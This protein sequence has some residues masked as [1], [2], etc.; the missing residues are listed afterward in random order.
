MS[1]PTKKPNVLFILIDDMGWKDLGCYGSAFYET[2]HLD[3]LA[4][5]GI[6]FTDAYAAAPVCSPTRASIMSGKYPANVG[7]TNWIGGR[8][9]GKLIDA[10]YIRHLP[11]QEKSVASA[12][13]EQGYRTWHVGKWH[14]GGQDHYPDKHGF[15]VNIGGC[16]WGMPLNGF[17]SPYGI[18]TLEEGPVGEYLTDRLTDEAIRL[19][20]QND[21]TPF[22]LNLW[23][24]AVH[25]PIE[26]SAE[27]T[28][29]FAAKARS[30]GLDQLDP[31]VAGEPFPCEHKQHLRVQRRMIQSDPAY[32]AM[33]YNL[34]WNIGR[35]IEALE[36]TE[37]LDDTVIVFTS[38]NGGLATAEGSPTCNSPLQEG[39]GWMYEGGVREPLIVRWSGVVKP[40][41]ISEVPVSS[42]DFY[43]TLLEIAGAGPL[44]E[45]HE[46]GVSFVPLLKGEERLDREALFWHYPHYG[47]QGGTPG[48]AVREG[49]YKLIEFFE[50]GRLELYNLRTDLSEASTIAGEQPEITERLHRKLRDWR[51]RIEAKIPVGNPAYSR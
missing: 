27:L 12:L 50:D 10:P 30:L 19:I 34:D 28:E 42:P 37:Q 38:D 15:D 31:F 8:T 5:E 41:S 4:A 16:S 20:R 24:Y 39:K 49:V 3:R 1:Q 25:I 46:D 29:R 44:P 11:L 2:P 43:P 23:H 36:E 18:E 7:V 40:G 14:L 32:A 17:F 47:N 13:K 35:L 33:I 6:R 45:Q 48:S 51:E 26:V 21:G 9:A 22:F